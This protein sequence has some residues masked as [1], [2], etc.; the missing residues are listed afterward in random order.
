M[1]PAPPMLCG[2]RPSVG[3]S[4]HLCDCHMRAMITIA[5]APLPAALVREV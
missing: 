1:M 2:C 4:S 5:L 3:S